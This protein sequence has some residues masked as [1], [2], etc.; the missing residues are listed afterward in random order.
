MF[1]LELKIKLIWQ[2]AIPYQAEQDLTELSHTERN[3]GPM[4]WTNGGERSSDEFQYDD[5]AQQ[6]ISTPCILVN[7]FFLA[8]HSVC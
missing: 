8:W 5:W 1:S 2:I 3:L 6:Q 4:T 7:A